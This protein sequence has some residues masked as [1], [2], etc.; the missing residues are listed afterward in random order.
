MKSFVV[1]L[2]LG[3]LLVVGGIF[4]V[5]QCC[6][7]NSNTAVVECK[8]MEGKPCCCKEHKDCNCSCDCGCKTGKDCVCVEKDH[9]K[10]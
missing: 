8:C 2:V 1:S 10:D 7:V 5:R 9:C 3:F 4:C 6:C